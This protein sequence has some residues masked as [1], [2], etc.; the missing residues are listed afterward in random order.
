MDTCRARKK[1]ITLKCDLI[2]SLVATRIL[3]LNHKKLRRIP[4][5]FWRVL[6]LPFNLEVVVS[7]KENDE[8][9]R[10]IVSSDEHWC[11]KTQGM[12]I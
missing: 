7:L 3:S 1:S 11:F 2:S 4:H 12:K 9:F 10:F 5:V 6:Q 8:C